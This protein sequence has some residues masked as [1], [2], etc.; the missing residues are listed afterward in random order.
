ML[1]LMIDIIFRMIIAIIYALFTII[2][3]VMVILFVKCPDYLH[4]MSIL[5]NETIIN[6][7]FNYIIDR[8][9]R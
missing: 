6:S 8:P 9:L 4:H 2:S 3:N 5:K 7:S 1:T